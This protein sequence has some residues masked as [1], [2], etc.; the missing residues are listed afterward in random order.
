MSHNETARRAL[1]TSTRAMADRIVATFNRATPANLADGLTW[2]PD[3]RRLVADVAQA[4]G[5]PVTTAAAVFA[6]L[7]PRIQWARNVAAATAFLAGDARLP[8]VMA[9]SWARAAKVSQAV[10]PLAALGA[11][12]AADYEKLLGR[13]GAYAAIAHAYRLAALRLGLNPCDVQAVCWVVARNGRK[14]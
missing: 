10:D 6:A 4:S 3:A 1:G 8:G 9:T 5:M 12:R 11:R 14:H 7:S 13:K 2:Y